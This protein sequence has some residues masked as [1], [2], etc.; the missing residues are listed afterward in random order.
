MTELRNAAATALLATLLGVLAGCT[1]A[2]PRAPSARG[3]AS[4]ARQSLQRL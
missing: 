1:S 2:A 3:A 4:P